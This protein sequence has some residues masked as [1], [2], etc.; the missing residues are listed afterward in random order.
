MRGGDRTA[1]VS[2]VAGREREDAV[3][4]HGRDDHDVGADGADRGA[5]L[6]LGAADRDIETV[7]LD[8]HA[9]AEAIG[10]RRQERT[11]R[12]RAA[13]GPGAPL[14]AFTPVRAAPGSAAPTQR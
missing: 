6:D 10:A 1:D 13:M 9:A 7:E 8:G 3:R 4:D 14:T 12:A 2:E 5:A 11:R